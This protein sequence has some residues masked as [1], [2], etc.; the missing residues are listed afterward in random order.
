[1]C[2]RKEVIAVTEISRESKV[3]SIG[4]QHS[5]NHHTP[6]VILDCGPGGPIVGSVT[7]EVEFSTYAFS[8]PRVSLAPNRALW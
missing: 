5:L 3:S 7:N 8:K 4:G 2:F 1:M 6:E